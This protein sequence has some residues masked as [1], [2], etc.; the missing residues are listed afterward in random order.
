MAAAISCLIL[1]ST[2]VP[3]GAAGTPTNSAFACVTDVLPT[4]GISPDNWLL[5]LSF[6]S[7]LGMDLGAFI[8]IFLV[9]GITT[10]KF[11]KDHKFSD[12]V[13]VLP[14]CLL[15]AFSFTL[16]SLPLARFI[17]SEITSLAAAAITV[18]VLL[19][20][21]KTG[22]LMPKDVWRFES[23]EAKAAEK[24]GDTVAT[25]HM[26]LLKAWTP[27]L[28]ISLWLV[29]TRIPQI[30]LKP[31]VQ[32]FSVSISNILGV[33]NAVWSFKYV[34]NPGIAPF[35][36]VVLIGILLYGLNGAQVKHMFVA[37]GRQV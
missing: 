1:N 31:I 5:S 12:A 6:I 19:G 11:G 29:L 27:Y 13:P 18:F 20:A 33:E 3:F 25:S 35:I 9:V 2:P 37:S 28:L 15:A 21:A 17:G 22:F 36:L 26:S 16:F 23:Q 14:F 7:A 4:L 10:Q 24:G 32:S 8:I 34:N 30:G